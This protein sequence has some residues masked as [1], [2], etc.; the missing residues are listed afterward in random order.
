MWVGTGLSLLVMIAGTLAFPGVRLQ[1]SPHKGR[2]IAGN[3]SQPSGPCCCWVRSFSAQAPPGFA[4]RA[5]FLALR[6]GFVG[7]VV[8]AKESSQ[9]SGW[10]LSP[11]QAD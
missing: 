8:A 9:Q 5:L 7:L 2:L 1:L 11:A 4:G 6:A 10:Q 3:C